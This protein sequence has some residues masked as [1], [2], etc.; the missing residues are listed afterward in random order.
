[1]L[2]AESAVS[3]FVLDAEL[4]GK[5]RE[6]MTPTG[7]EESNSE[8]QIATRVSGRGPGVLYIHGWNHSHRIW[9][10]TISELDN[11]ITSV[12][13]DLPGF[14]K[15]SSLPPSEISLS[16]YSSLTAGIIHD[17]H[18]LLEERSSALHTVVGDSLGALFLLELL[19]GNGSLMDQ[20]AREVNL[21]PPNRRAKITNEPGT[22]AERPAVQLPDRIIMS[23]C[24][25]DGL[26]AHI[27]SI[28]NLN[29]IKNGL[30]T[31]DA[32]PNWASKSLLRVLSLGTVYRFE[33]VK[34]DLVESVL[35]AE[36]RT[37]EMMF[38]EIADYSFDP[39]Q[40]P[41]SNLAL[42]VSVVRGEWDRVTSESENRDLANQLDGTY[43]EIPKVGHTPM[44]EAPQA[45]A[46]IVKGE[47]HL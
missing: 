44:I 10:Y 7:T 40:V 45:Y 27:S 26:P 42:D 31:L 25:V 15:S 5:K 21:T 17:A 28:K 3:L 9:N 12:A 37:S 14:G 16:D 33:D 24:P 18:Q 23:G 46:K 20:K 1:M 32:I 35:Q 22:I 30:S 36:P 29:I 6:Q 41:E 39:K 4:S 11:E 43:R 34:D 8:I 2:L 38:R 13:I 19:Q 47:I